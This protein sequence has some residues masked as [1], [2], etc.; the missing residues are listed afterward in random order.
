MRLA[1]AAS[2]VEVSILPS[3]GN[4]VIAMK[5]YTGRTFCT[6]HRPIW[7]S[8]KKNPAFSGIPFLA[9]WANRLDGEDFWANGNKY[10]FNMSLGNVRGAIPIH[11]LLSSSDLWEVTNV[12]GG[13]GCRRR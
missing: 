13:T 9:P 5:A 11:G 4:Q 8:F 3:V 10:I 1:D 6:F 7:R 12:S 2:G